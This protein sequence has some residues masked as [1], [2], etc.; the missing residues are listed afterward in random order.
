ML[1][2]VLFLVTHTCIWYVNMYWRR[3]CMLHQRLIE[4]ELSRRGL[5]L[6]GVDIPSDTDAGPF[7]RSTAAR[8]G[9]M[10]RL[11]ILRYGYC[12]YRVA[13]GVD[14]QGLPVTIWFQLRFA[15]RR[16]VEVTT[17]QTQS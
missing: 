3:A 15:T 14:A 6:A 1:V 12:A 4:R 10:A 17:A 2:F 7:N 9:I 16:V 5:R 8:S 13:H 11:S